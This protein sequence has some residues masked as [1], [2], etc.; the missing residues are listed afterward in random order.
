MSL[1]EFLGHVYLSGPRQLL[2]K[3]IEKS[4]MSVDRNALANICDQK[5]WFD[6]PYSYELPVPD[7]SVPTPSAFTNNHNQINISQPFVF[8]VPNI[9][10][11]GP[12]VIA[13]TPQGRY[14]IEETVGKPEILTDAV[15]KSLYY[16]KLPL[17]QN[18]EATYNRPI[19]SLAGMQSQ[20][21]FHWFADYLPRIRG[22]EKYAEVTGNYPDVILPSEPP[23]WLMTS[24]QYAGIPENRVVRWDGD[25]V[26]AERLVI[27]SVPR[28]TEDQSHLS[29]SPRALNWLGER[30]RLNVGVQTENV[31]RILITRRDATTRRIVN[32]D[33]VIRKL[34]PLGFEPVNLS[35][36]PYEEQVELFS[37]AEAVI[38]PH[39]A[40]LINSIYS[41]DIKILELFG[42][43]VTP[44]Y[45]NICKGLGHRYRYEV[46][47]TI[48]NDNA[49]VGISTPGHDLIVDANR[50][51]NVTR[52]W[53]CKSK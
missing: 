8:E 52:T 14:I 13:I 15:C 9:Q 30:I 25:R 10:L 28:N 26:N 46:C 4:R 3:A 18:T 37:R 48:E 21:Y 42:E 11:V 27:P 34:A 39:G 32:E 53:I 5:I 2:T 45:Y 44:L 7:G 33:E 49:S 40:G 12:D 38:A 1:L 19:V 41:E 29:Y 47:S 22:I 31:E 20:A 6:E 43:F 50:V 16:K 23:E 51:E 24:A 35:N 36:T 17:R